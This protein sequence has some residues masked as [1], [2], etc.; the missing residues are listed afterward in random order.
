MTVTWNAPAVDSCNPAASAYV[1]YLY[2][3]ATGTGVES[4]VVG[5]TMTA[6]GLTPNTY[7]IATIINWNGSRWVGWSNWS[8]WILAT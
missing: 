4:E 2:S 7:Y 5:N 1:V 6:T 8:N 3:A